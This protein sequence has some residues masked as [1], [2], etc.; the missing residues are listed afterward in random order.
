MR[1]ALDIK[2]SQL[3]TV[4]ARLAELELDG[5]RRDSKFTDQK[6][7]LKTVKEEYQEKFLALEAKYEAQKAIILR[8]E[9]EI[10]D[11]YKNQTAVNLVTLSP[12]S[13]K[14]G[15]N[16]FFFFFLFVAFVHL[17]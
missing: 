7:L 12:D 4:K 5:S 11:L 13:E 1:S 6:R 16:V 3:D 14:T 8:L 2:S 9:E 10:L 17:K 15:K